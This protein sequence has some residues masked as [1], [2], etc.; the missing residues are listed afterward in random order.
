MLTSK[1]RSALELF[2]EIVAE[3]FRNTGHTFKKEILGV[4]YDLPVTKTLVRE[5]IW[6][7]IQKTLFDIDSTGDLT[8][9]QMDMIIDVFVKHF[10]EKGYGLRFPS[11]YGRL[12]SQLDDY[13][14]HNIG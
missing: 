10:G 8:T 12:M 6:K 4:T 13:L 11:S 14:K 5:Q 2:F 3:A 7:P 9:S 1:Q